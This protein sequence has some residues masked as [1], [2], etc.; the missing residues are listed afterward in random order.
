[1]LPTLRG[2]VAGGRVALVW[3]LADGLWRQHFGVSA[4]EPSLKAGPLA[5][6]FARLLVFFLCQRDKLVP[7]RFI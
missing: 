4:V 5:R 2:W 6:S 7:L 1:M 3:C